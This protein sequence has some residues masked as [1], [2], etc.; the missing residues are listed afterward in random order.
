M[1]IEIKVGE[2]PTITIKI[3]ESMVLQPLASKLNN[4]PISGHHKAKHSPFLTF[5]GVYIYEFSQQFAETCH[6][7]PC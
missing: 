7:Y 1:I 5:K 6:S 4:E 2:M 3:T